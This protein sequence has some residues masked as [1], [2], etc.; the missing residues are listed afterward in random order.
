MSN[1]QVIMA[2]L[3]IVAPIIGFAIAPEDLTA[4][5]YSAEASVI[6]GT[7]TITETIDFLMGSGDG[8]KKIVSSV[9]SIGDDNYT[10]TL[11][12]QSSYDIAYNSKLTFSLNIISNSNGTSL[13]HIPL[14]NIWLDITG[15]NSY[16]QRLQ[17]SGVSGD[18]YEFSMRIPIMGKII[19]ALLFLVAVLWFTEIIPLEA[20]SLLI[21]VMIVV[22]GVTSSA[23]ALK[24]FFDPVIALFLGG[25]LIARAMRKHDVDKFIALKMVSKSSLD[26]KYLML[27]MMGLSAFL[28]LWMSN[29][30]STAVL[31]PIAVSILERL[32]DAAG[33]KF[34][35]GLVLGIA[36][37]ATIGGIGSAIGT[38]ANPMA[39]AFL[40]SYADRSISFVEW[41]LFGIPFVIPMLII[42]WLYLIV[43]FKPGKIPKEKM[44]QTKQAILEELQEMG[45]LTKEQKKVF[46]IFGFTVF[47]WLFQSIIVKGYKFGDIQIIPPLL[48]LIGMESGGLSSAIVALIG[49]VLLFVF[50]L[51]KSD[52]VSRINWS[53]LLIFG[54]GL[55]LGNMIVNTGV[56]D[57][58]ALQLG[59][60]L[61]STGTLAA[62][63][64]ISVVV[65]VL[66]LI[67]TMFASNT[68][69]AAMI[70]PL[71]I[72]LAAVLN[73]D[74][75]LL[76]VI[77]AMASSVD[78]ALVIG[79]PP[80]MIAFSTGYF[81]V[82][83][84]FR[85]GIIL[86][87]IGIIILTVCMVF[88]WMMLGIVTI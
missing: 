47:L 21:P 27:T 9:H 24:S 50:G 53:A 55:T 46:A 19:M 86:D 81:N 15:P 52:D 30:A 63:L 67:I 69:S 16:S 43:F 61:P 85:V 37:A 57:W 5:D 40:S 8:D 76:V 31:V 17:T 34:K 32:G 35:K 82:R 4:G 88:I 71:A 26:P 33:D 60:I 13:I 75:T 42:T 74:P 38:P 12:G 1:K 78:F 66:A 28:S 80:T 6:I 45:E 7:T 44:I 62:V 68:A 54:G 49:A 65:G 14:E 77:V 18:S 79:T 56:S 29:T 59:N 87:I 20:S 11:I 48:K 22:F 51:L 58:M 41:F 23:E 84:V 72:P 64:I 3:L 25:F 70:I 73:I 10:L 2:I 39:I 36:Y 83:E